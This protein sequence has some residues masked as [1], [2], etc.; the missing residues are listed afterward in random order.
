[1]QS[2]KIWINQFEFMTAENS[3]NDFIVS[4]EQHKN[5][6]E[7]FIDIWLAWVVL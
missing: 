4:L 3:F 2:A 5:T 7:N 1:M 6:N